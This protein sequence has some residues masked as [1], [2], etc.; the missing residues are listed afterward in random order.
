MELMTSRAPQRAQLCVALPMVE[1]RRGL[2]RGRPSVRVLRPRG[3]AGGLSD[4]AKE[5]IERPRR[6]GLLEDVHRRHLPV[7]VLANAALREGSIIL[8]G[9]R[10]AP[11]PV[12]PPVDDD[13][14]R[15]LP[16]E[17]QL[18]PGVDDGQRVPHPGEESSPMLVGRQRGLGAAIGDEHLEVRPVKVYVDPAQFPVVH[19]ANQMRAKIS[20]RPTREA[21]DADPRGEHESLLEGPRLRRDEE[22]RA[23][24]TE[25]E[26][27]SG[28]RL[29]HPVLGTGHFDQGADEPFPQ[30]RRLSEAAED[31]LEVLGGDPCH[32]DAADELHQQDGKLVA[33]SH[34][35][36]Q[37]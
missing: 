12:D 28:S 13:C 36:Q 3:L 6:H 29:H 23:R 33:A 2:R 15:L 16:E 19:E 26:E 32:A 5:R 1:I 7:E 37:M 4:V 10:D 21:L 35:L 9:E 34:G 30:R 17:A 25:V 18:R 31:R 24:S 14:Q 11:F 20:L 27:D 22:P 8:G